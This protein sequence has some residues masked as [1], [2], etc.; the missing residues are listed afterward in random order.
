MSRPP[1]GWFLST[2]IVLL[3][4]ICLHLYMPFEFLL[5]LLEVRPLETQPSSP[6]LAGSL[7]S[8]I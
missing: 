8:D 5:L 4:G 3:S 6:V 1:Q 2:Y 7:Y